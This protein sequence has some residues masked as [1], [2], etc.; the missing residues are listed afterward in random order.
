MVLIGGMAIAFVAKLRATR[1]GVKDQPS[2]IATIAHHE[3][4]RLADHPQMSMDTDFSDDGTEVTFLPAEDLRILREAD[5]D[6]ESV[7]TFLPE[8]HEAAEAQCGV[9]VVAGD[10]A[11]SAAVPVGTN[12]ELASSDDLSITFTQEHAEQ[13]AARYRLS[14]KVQGTDEKMRR[15]HAQQKTKR[16]AVSAHDFDLPTIAEQKLADSTARMAH[17][18]TAGSNVGSTASRTRAKKPVSKS[19]DFG[20]D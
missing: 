5:N 18:M 13:A 2:P 3:L 20:L 17:A 9:P 7:V 19:V 10:S 12:E 1:A 15:V 16:A 14:R 8:A 11:V 6:D 4:E